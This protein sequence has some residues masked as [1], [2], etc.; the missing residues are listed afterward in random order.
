MPLLTLCCF[1]LLLQLEQRVCVVEVASLATCRPC[2]H[3]PEFISPQA[4]WT[5][6][7]RVCVCVLWSMVV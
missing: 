2:L 3:A 4:M 6:W 7:E 5:F 1:G